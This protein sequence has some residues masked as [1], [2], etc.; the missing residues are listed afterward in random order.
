MARSLSQTLTRFPNS[1]S[2]AT[3]TRFVNFRHRSNSA[4]VFSGENMAAE[5]VEKVAMKNLEDAIHKIIVKKSQPDWISL[6]PGASYW[7]PP[8]SK[9]QGLANVIGNL[10][11]NSAAATAVIKGGN[12]GFSLSSNRGWPSS[13]HFF[14]GASHS[15]LEGETGKSRKT[16]SKH[17]SQF[18]DEEG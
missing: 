2:S 17:A 4:E 11:H 12:K 1:L 15:S 6:V 10:V 8:K 7:V 3:S 14:E 16:A 9:A 13:A 18:E 5:E